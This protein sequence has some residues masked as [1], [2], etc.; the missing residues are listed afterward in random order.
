VEEILEYKLTK[1]RQS[2]HTIQVT[3]SHAFPEDVIWECCGGTVQL[4]LPGFAGW[5]PVVNFAKRGTIYLENV[6]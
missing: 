3:S 1:I 5:L 4:D 2:N 6:G